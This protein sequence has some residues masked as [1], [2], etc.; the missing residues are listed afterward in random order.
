MEIYDIPQL[1]ELLRISEKGARRLLAT[2]KLTGRKVG[3]R[4]LVLDEAVIEFMM[5]TEAG[6]GSIPNGSLNTHERTANHA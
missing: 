2:G 3:K 1:A 6:N 5:Q 4:W